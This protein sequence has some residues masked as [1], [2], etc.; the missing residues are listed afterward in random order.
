[1]KFRPYYLTPVLVAGAAAAAIV[2]APTTIVAAARPQQAGIVTT[3]M[4][5]HDYRRLLLRR[6][7]RQLTRLRLLS[8]RARATD[9]ALEAGR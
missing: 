4:A 6:F 2:A 1:M 8:R 9:T 7:L 5:G 3:P